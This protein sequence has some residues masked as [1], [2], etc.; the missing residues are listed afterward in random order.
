ML[1]KKAILKSSYIDNFSANKCIL[2][3]SVGQVNHEGDKFL[4]TVMAV[5]KK[6]SFC[7]VMVCDSLQRFTMKFVSSLS[8][9][10]I[11]RESNFLGDEWI[12]RN[13]KALRQ[14]SIPYSI[15]RW[16]CWISHPHF[17]NKKF[18]IDEL[19]IND[20]HFKEIVDNTAYSF[21]VRKLDILTVDKMYAINLSKQYL[22]E[23]CAVMLIQA[24]DMNGFEIYPSQR[25]DAMAYVHKKI[26]SVIDNNLMH[27]VSIKFKNISLTE[28]S[29]H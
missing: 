5:D 11:H 2:T 7:T 26:I 15:S 22:L 17:K 9:E 13:L 14:L 8:L 12:K 25:N 3:I 16:D 27:P 4:S 10:E 1:T 29:I 18:L 24:D 28:V 23:E 21:V 19:Y 6:F 20:K